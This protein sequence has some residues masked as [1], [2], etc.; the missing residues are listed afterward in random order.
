MGFAETKADPIVATPT[1][2]TE[3]SPALASAPDVQMPAADQ[4]RAESAVTVRTDLP[5]RQSRDGR[6]NYG[7][8]SISRPRFEPSTRAPASADGA[9]GSPRQIAEVASV[10]ATPHDPT[11]ISV[12]SN[13][14]GWPG[15]GWGGG[16][17]A[18][19]ERD[20]GAGTRESYQERKAR[21]TAERRLLEAEALEAEARA[22]LVR[23]DAA[24]YE[25]NYGRPAVII[26]GRGYYYGGVRNG[27]TWRGAPRSSR[28]LVG[29]GGLDAPRGEVT[30]TR[31]R[32]VGTKA[33]SEFGKAASREDIIATQRRIDAAVRGDRLK[34]E[35]VDE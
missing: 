30:I 1:S 27:R 6:V 16:V 11:V 5:S 17:N 26:G 7:E 25:R 24:H 10:E 14:L 21:E 3:T 13:T 19:G 9:E 28:S 34:L 22:E 35:P 31:E 4:P 20:A 12:P 2:A 33:Q 15:E 8:F 18:G 29:E 32:F 23:L